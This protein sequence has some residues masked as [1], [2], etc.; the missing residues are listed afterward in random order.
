[1]A[2]RFPKNRRT[3]R[4]PRLRRPRLPRPARQA[5]SA[6]ILSMMG[7]SALLMPTLALGE[8]SADTGTTQELNSSTTLYIDVIDYTKDD[9]QWVGSGDLTIYDPDDVR[10]ATLRSGRSYKPKKNG[11][12]RA[13]MARNNNSWSIDVKGTKAGMGRVWAYQWQFDA[14]SFSSTRALNGSFYA[15]VDGGTPSND[16]VV[17]L[18]PDGLAGYVYTVSANSYG[19]D[20][21]SARSQL[22]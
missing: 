19:L 8:G 16:G 20:S 17:E 14:G 4:S 1:M 10:V 22:G 18:K 6:V 12:F 7:T 13:Q 21:G 15:I 2:I 5:T 11:V 3:L 9:I